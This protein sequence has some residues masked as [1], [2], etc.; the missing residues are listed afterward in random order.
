MPRSIS[1]PAGT[2]RN[3]EFAVTYPSTW[4][5]ALKRS[6]NVLAADIS[7]ARFLLKDEI[8]SPDA[9]AIVTK[10]TISGIT[11]GASDG[12]VTVTL[13]PADTKE[14]EGSYVGTLRLY[15]VGGSVVDFE[16]TTYPDIYY[17]QI[18]ITQGAVEATS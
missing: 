13:N 18:S 14:L 8:T 17:I 16:D 3:I 10:T 4:S 7:S 5:V 6:T 15:L 2:T 12:K 9:S 1:V 11:I